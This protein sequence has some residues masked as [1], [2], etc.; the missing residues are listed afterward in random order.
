MLSTAPPRV[1][2]A[3]GTCAPPAMPAVSVDAF[4]TG[5]SCMGI[6]RGEPRNYRR[7]ARPRRRRA[8]RGRLSRCKRLPDLVECRRVLDRRQIAGLAPFGE[9]LDRTPKELPG[10]GLRQQ[11]DEMH[12]AGTRDRAK[13]SVDSLGD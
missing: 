2:V 12:G 4:P 11:R 9:R 7:F 13:L 10:P 8:H 1:A 3:S 6:W 5:I